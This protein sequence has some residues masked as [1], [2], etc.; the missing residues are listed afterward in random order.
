LIDDKNYPGFSILS[1]AVALGGVGGF[2][3][4]NNITRVKA[5]PPAMA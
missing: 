1:S 3:R 4:K 2:F 5:T